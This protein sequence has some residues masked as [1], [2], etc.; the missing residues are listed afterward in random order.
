MKAGLAVLGTVAFLAAC[1]ESHSSETTHAGATEHGPGI[2]VET[3]EIQVNIPVEGTVV[4]R[5]RAEITTRMMARVTV[6][7][8][9]VG[10]RVRAGQVL[11]L[12]GTDDIAVNRA[13]AEAAV[14]VASAARDEAEKHANRMDALLAQDVVPEVQRDHAHFQLTQAEAQVAMATASLREV[15]TAGSYASI[16]APFDGEVV[17]RYIDE[18]DVAA[19]GMPLLVVEEEG[20]REGRLAVP[21]GAAEG[22]EIGSTVRVTTLGGRSHEAP[23]R[24][25]SAGADPISKT[26]EVRVVL[27][28]DWPTG[29]SLTALVPTGTTRAVTI[30][31]E[32]VVRRGQLTGVRVVTSS[33]AALRWIRLGRSVGEDRVEVLSGLSAGDEIVVSAVES[34]TSDDEA[35]Q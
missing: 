10:S 33:G 9:D 34:A 6:L 19:P 4:A 3:E 21:V 8:A 24:A 26:V 29:V 13:K 2:T 12:L 15:E 20:A 25:V 17:S 30:P 18:G 1:G 31:L 16:R 7:S 28:A 23:V 35:V 11:L 22:L 32:V 14:M 27:P 5:N